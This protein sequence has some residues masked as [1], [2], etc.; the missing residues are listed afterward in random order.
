MLIP[1]VKTERLI[2]RGFVESDFDAYA[3]MCADPEVMRYL[4]GQPLPR[5]EA[6]RN[7][8]MIV[9]HWYLRGY[10]F[11][12]VEEQ[13]TGQTIGRIGCWQP[14][15]WLG[16]EVGWTLHRPYWGRGYATE[17]ARASVDYAFS[18]LG[19]LQV[20]HYIDPLNQASQQ[21]A[22]RL[23]AKV[24][25]TTPLFGRDVLVYAI[26]REDWQ[27]SPLNLQTE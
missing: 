5:S 8:A 19:Q 27:L 6:W 9:G 10:G 14:E 25:Q 1:Q 17:A 18:E 21:V 23:G 26:N 4:G 22:L 20:I 7:M 15:G 3:E 11:W 24:I 13:A 2:L 12:A 16:L